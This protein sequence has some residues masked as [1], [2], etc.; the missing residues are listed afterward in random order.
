MRWSRAGIGILCVAA[1]AAGAWWVLGPSRANMRQD[2][3]EAPDKEASKGEHEE[4]GAIPMTPEKRQALGLKVEPVQAR[5]PEARLVLTGKIAPNPDRTVAVVPRV[6]GRAVKVNAQLGDT[7]EAGATLALLDSVE[8]AETLADLSHSE[9][10]LALAQAEYDRESLLVERKIGA[11][12]D[13]IRAEAALQQARAQRNRATAKLR[14]LGLSEAAITQALQ[15]PGQRL[16]VPLL[17]P[18]RGTVIE[19]QISEG[20]LLDAAAVPFR[21]ADLS[22]VWA[23]LDIPESDI[24]LVR[25]GQEAAVEAG[26]DAALKHTGRVVFIADVVEEQTRTIKVR[27]EIPNRERHFKPGMFVTARLNIRQPGRAVLMVPRDAVV[28]LDERAVVFIDRGDKIEAQPVETDPTV[29]G[30]VPVRK[31]LTAGDPVVVEGAFA[32]KAQLVK[33]KLGEE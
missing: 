9:S 16:L 21:V 23:L 27:V 24:A 11:R 4:G 7:V 15:Q 18:F 33:A 20:Q 12:K 30:W 10:V 2:R 29:E 28:L 31:G 22:T 1:L 3:Q 6:P 8:A 14:A 19:R 17:A 5:V 13:M 26:R 25:V 32:L